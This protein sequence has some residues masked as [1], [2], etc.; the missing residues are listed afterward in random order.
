MHNRTETKLLKAELNIHINTASGTLIPRAKV[1]VHHPK[2][3]YRLGTSKVIIQLILAGGHYLLSCR[4]KSGT[5]KRS[6]HARKA[7]Q[8]LVIIN[9]YRS[10]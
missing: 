3:Y 9:Q 8:T 5:T 6:L 10:S 1:N 7:K 2:S 4:N